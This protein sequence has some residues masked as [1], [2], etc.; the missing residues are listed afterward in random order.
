M[1]VDRHHV[2]F[3]GFVAGGTVV[4]AASAARPGP[5][6]S[7]Q[8]LLEPHVL[9]GAVV[10]VLAAL[11]VA[12][13]A[14]LAFVLVRAWLTIRRL[15]RIDGVPARLTSS[16]VRTGVERVRCL[17]SG[18][19]IA[20]CAG[21]VRPEVIVSEGLVEELNDH[22]LD[23]VL[24]H[25]RHHV[26]ELEPM[27]RAASEAAAEVLFLCPIVRWWSRRRIEEAEL[28]A[29]QAAVRVVGPRPVAA[30]LYRLSCTMPAETAFAGG[31]D[32]RVAQLLGDP[33]PLRRP[34]AWT[35]ASSLLGLPVAVAVAGCVILGVAPLIGG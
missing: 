6:V 25:E 31:A 5:L 32:M 28:R 17:S 7:L 23:A 3:L 33:L 21:V 27:A 30:A 8:H 20:F 24:L 34:G 16:V 19:P 11:L 29:D 12:W 18:L 4:I 10:S 9:T 14:R 13:T 2:S 35:I 1:K 26:R 15:P 22:E